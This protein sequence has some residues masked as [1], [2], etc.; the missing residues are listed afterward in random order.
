MRRAL[1]VLTVLAL[2]T[3]AFAAEEKKKEGE[4]D[5]VGQYIDLVP[6]ALPI[7]A[8]GMVRNYIFLRVRVN[9]TKSADAPKMRDK[10][11]YLRDALLHA[12]YRTPFTRTDSY[13]KVDEAKLS[14]SLARDAAAIL[15]PGKVASVQVVS[16]DPQRISGVGRP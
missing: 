13:L 12:G 3:P 6:L 4:G 16:Q 2:S 1:I 7:V 8:D 11:P 5:A 9:L 14:A 10:E 15:G